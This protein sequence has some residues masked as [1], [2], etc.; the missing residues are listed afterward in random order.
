MFGHTGDTFVPLP[1]LPLSLSL[2]PPS[3]GNVPVAPARLPTHSA[4][5]RHLA[6]HHPVA[7]APLAGQEEVTA[8]SP[9]PPPAPRRGAGQPRRATTTPPSPS[10][11]ARAG[12][13]PQD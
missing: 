8:V 3:P 7:A 13:A 9:L 11:L 5:P 10:C 2:S 6:L 1:T 4:L 12:E